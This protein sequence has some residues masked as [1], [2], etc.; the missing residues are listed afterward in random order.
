LSI[1]KGYMYGKL[2]ANSKLDTIPQ[3]LIGKGSN[4][5]C[6]ITKPEIDGFIYKL[7]KTSNLSTA[8]LNQIQLKFQE[9]K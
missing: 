9:G 4:I 7:K 5:G 1:F 2:L 8:D 3:I 6:P